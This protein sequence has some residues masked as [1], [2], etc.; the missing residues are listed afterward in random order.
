MGWRRAGAR[1]E[2]AHDEGGI[3]HGERREG[4]SDAEEDAL[5]DEGVRD[6]RQRCRAAGS[7]ARPSTDIID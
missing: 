1:L 6:L 3:E 4:G 2:D 7:A 5:V